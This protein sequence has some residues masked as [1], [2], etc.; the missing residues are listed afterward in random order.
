[1][2]PTRERGLEGC[3]NMGEGPRGEA[4]GVEG[5]KRVAKRSSMS[6]LVGGG[7]G[8]PVPAGTG[9]NG[10]MESRGEGI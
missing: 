7:M 8:V 6:V 5:V 4:G 10:E 2:E 3:E 1:M 9:I